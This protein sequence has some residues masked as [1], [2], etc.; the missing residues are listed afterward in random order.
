MKARVV[1]RHGTTV[2]ASCFLVCLYLEQVLREDEETFVVLFLGV[3]MDSFLMMPVERSFSSTH[4]VSLII[5]ILVYLGSGWMK[6]NKRFVENTLFFVRSLLYAG[7]LSVVIYLLSGSIYKSIQY[8]FEIWQDEAERIIAYTA[9]VVFSIIFPLLFLMFNERRER[10][11]LPF[12][13]KLFDVLLNYVLSPALLIYA[14]ILYLYFIKIAVLWS[15]PK[16]AVASIVVSFTAAA[17]ILKDVRFF[18]PGGITIGF[19]IMP[20]LLCFRRW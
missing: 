10:S 16:G 2:Y 3:V 4:L 18:L 8:I 6:D 20:A 1:F 14:V 5:V 9:F 15:L 7:G 13:S 11:W 17:F 19:M 12:K